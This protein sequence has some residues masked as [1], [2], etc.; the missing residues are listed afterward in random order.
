MPAATPSLALPY[1]V[2]DDQVDVPRDIKALADA[3]DLQ[4]VVPIGTIL[5]WAAAA[6]PLGWL[7]CNGSV[8]PAG[9]YPRLAQVLGQSGGQ[10]TL[11][12]LVG[13]I[14]VGV[15]ANRPLKSVGGVET[16]ALA[17]AQLPAHGHGVDDPGHAHT[18]ATAGYHSHGGAT[19]GAD[20]SL[21][22]SHTYN[23]RSGSEYQAALGRQT[24]SGN[25]APPAHQHAATS[26]WSGAQGSPDHTHGIYAD[27]NHSHG[28]DYRP[29]GVVIRPTGDGAAHENMP[30]YFVVNFIIRAG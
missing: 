27:G 21:A 30:P 1:P 16:V 23:D 22:H 10:I 19:V 28:M 25:A 18:I 6:S 20:R 5:M 2:P 24:G 13:K 15:A 4:G 14:P 12:N 17:T 9:T 8:L 29:T 11:P 7:L 26:T 3:M